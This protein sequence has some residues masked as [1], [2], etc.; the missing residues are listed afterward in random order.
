MRPAIAVAVIVFLSLPALTQTATKKATA[1]EAEKI[2]A[3]AKAK[4]AAIT[5][6]ATSSISCGD[7]SE[8][9]CVGTD[10]GVIS[11]VQ[12]VANETE[13]WRD[14]VKVEAAK[15]DVILQFRVK[16]IRTDYGT[17]SLEA[18][19][20][21]TNALLW[22]EYRPVV[23]LENDVTRMVAHFL[24]VRKTPVGSKSLPK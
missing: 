9:T 10:T 6:I 3:L 19:D 17:I 1:E 14:L 4:S 24:K 11:Q 7:G 22:S 5:V 2:M 8:G 15:A 21:D 20:A 23:D 18:R 16:N 12:R 13:L